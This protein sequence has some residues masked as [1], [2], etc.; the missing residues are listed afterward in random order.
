MATVSQLEIF[1][2]ALPKS[3][4]TFGDLI[5]SK[6]YNDKAP[7][8]PESNLFKKLYV[9]FLEP[10]S[11]NNVWEYESKKKGLTIFK[12]RPNNVNRIVVSHS[13]AKVIEGYID[14]GRYDMIR[15]LSKMTDNT[16]SQDIG[17][18]DIVAARYYF[19]LYVPLDKSIAVLFLEKKRDYQIGDAFKKFLSDL[20]KLKNLCKIDSYIPPSMIE[21]YKNGAMVESLTSIDYY[22]SPTGENDERRPKMYEVTVTVKPIGEATEYENLEQLESEMRELDVTFFQKTLTFCHFKKRK[23]TIKNVDTKKISTYDYE[24]GEVIRPA[25]N[26]DDDWINNSIVDRNKIK[27]CCEKILNDIKGDI[28]GVN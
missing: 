25:I 10:L 8:Q 13:T 1:K 15:T 26:I 9:K 23:A 2:V 11:K 17:T 4:G 14:G 19:Y 7:R 12:S 20:F 24:K 16:Q 18:S 22:S 6:Y 27:A 28:Y 21:E 5:Q 3:S